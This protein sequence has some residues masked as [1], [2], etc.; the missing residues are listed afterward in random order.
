[1]LVQLGNC[2]KKYGARWIVERAE[3]LNRMSL[4]QMPH[5]GL[6]HGGIIRS[7]CCRQPVVFERFGQADFFNRIDP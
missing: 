1:M 5:S 7:C 2:S 6:S 3:Q 4:A